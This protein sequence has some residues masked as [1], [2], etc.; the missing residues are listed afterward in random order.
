MGDGQACLY[1]DESPKNGGL[2]Y[3]LGFQEEKEPNESP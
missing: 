3:L 1:A 2:Q